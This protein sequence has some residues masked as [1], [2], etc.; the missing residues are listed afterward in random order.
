[1][2]LQ[3]DLNKMLARQLKRGLGL[4]DS[5]AIE[6]LQAGTLPSEQL[7][8]LAAAIPRFI[9]MVN[10]SYTQYDRDLNLRTRS[11]ELS[12]SELSS[13]NEKLRQQADSQQSVINALR[14][15]ANELLSSNH[16]PPIAEDNADLLGI[17]QVLRN[18]LDQRKTAEAEV[19]RTRTQLINAISS[20]DAGFAMY[21]Q[22]QRL[23]ICNDRFRSIYPNLSNVLTPGTAY[24]QILEVYYRTTPSLHG[25]IDE[26]TWVK[27]RIEEQLQGATAQEVAI[28]DRWIRIDDTRTSD[29]LLVCL[30]T[31]ITQLKQLNMDLTSAKEVAEAANLAKSE[32]LANM[33]H[34]IRTPM[35]G[36]IGMTEL[37]LDTE[38]TS[39]QREYLSLVKSSADAL[40]V[41]INDILDFSKIEAGKMDVET[42]PFSIRELISHSVTPLAHKAHEKNLE[43]V[44][45]VE[46]TLHDGYQGD[47]NRLRQVITNLL[48]NA[49]KF[50]QAGEVVLHAAVGDEHNLRLSISDTGIGIPADK[51]ET[52]FQAFSQADNSTTRKYGGTGLGLTICSRLV[53]LMGGKI[54]LESNVGH[55]S[56]FHIE[57]PLSEATEIDNTAPA[58]PQELEGLPVLIV[59]DNAT[60]RLWLSRL[61]ANWNIRVLCAASAHEA[62]TL[63]QNHPELALLVLDVNMPESSGLDLVDWFRKN[64]PHHQAKI[65]MLSSSG[66]R[67]DKLRATALQVDETLTKPIYQDELQNCILLMFGQKET[68]TNSQVAE[69]T[70]LPLLPQM[71][72]LLTEDNPVNQKLALRILE[73]LGQNVTLAENGKQAVQRFQAEHFD[74]LLMD[75]QMPEMGGFEATALIRDYE[76]AQNSKP[77]PIIAMT[78]HA[79][80]GDRESCLAAGM[81]GYVSKPINT[82]LLIEEILRVTQLEA[83]PVPSPVRI[84]TK[85]PTDQTPLLDET[86]A[87]E[88]V[89][90]DWPLLLELLEIFIQDLTAQSRQISVALTQGDSHLAILAMHTLKGSASNISAL[91][92]QRQAEA[93]ETGVKQRGLDALMLAWPELQQTMDETRIH[94]QTLLENSPNSV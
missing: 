87:L 13:V 74:L 83:L 19:L 20:L 79:M 2:T 6:Q 69:A 75:V 68:L 85:M 27:R 25:R 67:D 10:D 91:R 77:T 3:F 33:S 9:A 18:L 15:S 14:D 76:Q 52:V 81:N 26:A 29:G 72:I 56:I 55:G 38:L 80:Q 78:A 4:A 31:D 46:P 92:L 61:F 22:E 39:E 40:L 7:V 37:A 66:I 36:V 35:N 51:Q 57:L 59:D 94:I 32:F 28:G 12:S 70:R 34:E 1:M 88:R 82:T 49:I 43:L 89:G 53:K 41:I 42:I 84:A 5:E 90:D 11:L 65:L 44:C 73:K 8:Q 60:N 93:L 54:W 58:S 64:H 86:D 16:L 24:R 62:H 21:D 48:S 50:T 17:S 30:R 71:S 63:I 45:I 23:V 47:P